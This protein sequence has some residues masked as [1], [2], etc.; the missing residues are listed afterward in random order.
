M[1]ATLKPQTQIE[2]PHLFQ[3][4]ERV[5]SVYGLRPA[6]PFPETEDGSPGAGSSNAL[7]AVF[8]K[9]YEGLKRNARERHKITTVAR[10]EF[11]PS[12]KKKIAE[13][14]RVDVQASDNVD[15][16]QL[17]Q[18]A[19][20]G[21]HTDISD[22][23]SARLEEL[24]MS[25]TARTELLSEQ[26]DS[27]TVDD[28][29]E[30]N[31]E[32]VE[33][34]RREDDN[35]TITAGDPAIA[36]A[37]KRWN[38][39]RR[40]IWVDLE[41]GFVASAHATFDAYYKKRYKKRQRRDEY[42][43]EDNSE[44]DG[45]LFDLESYPKYENVHT[46]TIT[47]E[48]FGLEAWEFEELHNDRNNTIMVNYSDPGCI[49]ARKLLRRIDELQTS[50]AKLGWNPPQDHE[51]LKEFIDDTGLS[52][53][54]TTNEYKRSTLVYSNLFSFL[55]R[56]DALVDFRSTSTVNTVW[57]EGSEGKGGKFWNL[58]WQIVVAKELIRRFEV[59][60]TVGCTF[61]FTGRILA[62]MIIAD[63][64]L[65]NIEIGLSEMK[66]QPKDIKQ[67][68]TDEL[69]A[70]A[71]DFKRQGGDAMAKKDYH[72]AIY[73]YTEAIRIDPSSSV[74]EDAYIAIRLDDQAAVEA[75]ENAIALAG[76]GATAGMRQG[77]QDAR[78]ANTANMNAINKEKD[79]S[80]KEVFRKEFIEQ[81]FEIA[82]K[83]VKLRSGQLT[84]R[85]LQDWLFSL[86]LPGKWFSFKIMSTL[87][88]CTPSLSETLGVAPYYNCGLSLP[89]RSY[90]RIRT[91]LGRVL[92]CQ[93]GTGWSDEDNFDPSKP[94]HINLKARAVT[95]I[96]H[97]GWINDINI[98][99]GDD[100]EDIKYE[101]EKELGP[102]MEEMK[103]QDNWVVLEPPGRQP[104]AKAVYRAQLTFTL[105]DT[106][107]EIITYKLYTNPVFV[108]PPP[109][110]PCPC[111]V[112]HEV[113][114]RELPCYQERNIWTIE[115]LKEHTAEDDP[116][117]GGVMV[118][119]AT[120]RGAETLARA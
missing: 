87:I 32:D 67:P 34:I 31:W 89:K 69:K 27:F 83:T 55:N 47:V 46:G 73:S 70:K 109:C 68:E 37:E 62:S 29:D 57:N 36:V 113:R 80:K 107:S 30:E 75:Y 44:E 88:L 17:L 25:N 43:F 16:L 13:V 94:R 60:K 65:Q 51:D 28:L 6:T 90:W 35:I 92:G 86:I 7:S 20:I 59:D 38:G 101:G 97:K 54:N 91:V 74:L 11:V 33:Y 52:Y 45:V 106:P 39:K 50:S 108:V 103:N 111:G 95:P 15:E 96:A 114:R 12:I 84:P 93:T 99:T 10:R 112:A 105:D 100:Y 110:Q 102:W 78:E 104:D 2:S 4:L 81:D 72:K 48:G 14:M 22:V 77:L 26:L 76:Q 118:I 61:N 56:T 5:Q 49:P 24:A 79:L 63:Q 19:T 41:K 40:D 23:A 58:L 21:D 116:E 53:A 115:R 85:H 66:I 18:Y 8:A 42:G 120:G 9:S 98:V 64:W 3:D 71:E 1:R 119:N 82:A 117:R